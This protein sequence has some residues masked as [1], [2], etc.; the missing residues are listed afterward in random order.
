ML[1]IMTVEEKMKRK[2]DEQKRKKEI[3]YPWSVVNDE[4]FG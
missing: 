2:K 3:T 4:H 1:D